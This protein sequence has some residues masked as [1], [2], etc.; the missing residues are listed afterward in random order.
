[1]SRPEILAPAG[2]R[3]MLG[4]AVF[5]VTWTLTPRAWQK[6]TASCSSSG[7][8]LPAVRRALKPVSPR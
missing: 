8:K 2:N 6:E 5:S 7:V 1:M 4:A 3:E